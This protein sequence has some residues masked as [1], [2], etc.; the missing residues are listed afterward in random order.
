MCIRDRYNP[1]NDIPTELIWP[2]KEVEEASK[3]QTIWLEIPE[4]KIGGNLNNPDS[5]KWWNG[6]T[7]SLY[8]SDQN[9]SNNKYL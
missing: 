3:E 1:Y 6:I 4:N 2:D 5:N 8:A 7:A 9:Q